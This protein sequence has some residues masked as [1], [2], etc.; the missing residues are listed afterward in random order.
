M[1]K[2]RKRTVR[3]T[4]SIKQSSSE[5]RLFNFVFGVL[6]FFILEL[7]FMLGGLYIEQRILQ[8]PATGIPSLLGL[9]VWIGLSAIYKGKND[10]F[11]GGVTISILVPIILIVVTMTGFVAFSERMYAS[12]VAFVLLI[13]I[14]AF[15]F[16]KKR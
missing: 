4:Q 6:L 5:D 15:Y 12:I 13:L 10:L 8:I 14:S 7:I 2:K 3:R 16:A 1:P 11:L 9:I